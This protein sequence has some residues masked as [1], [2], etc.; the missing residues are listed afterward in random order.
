MD[1]VK[2]AT[3]SE[4]FPTEAQVAIM[5]ANITNPNTKLKVSGVPR[6]FTM[7]ATLWM[8][9]KL[10]VSLIGTRSAAKLVAQYAAYIGAEA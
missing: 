2:T 7:P 4:G 10:G 8:I 3:G 9:E 1:Y 5:R 6:T